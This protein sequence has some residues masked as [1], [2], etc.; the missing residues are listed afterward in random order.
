MR[1][2]EAFYAFELAGRLRRWR[3][4]RYVNELRCYSI[5]VGAL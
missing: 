4:W 2:T 1:L 3:F 5:A